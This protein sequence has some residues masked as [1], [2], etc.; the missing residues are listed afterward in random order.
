M[1]ILYAI[2][3]IAVACTAVLVITGL[4]DASSDA[5]PCRFGNQ[6]AP[7]FSAQGPVQDV[8]NAPPAPSGPCHMGP[9]DDRRVVIVPDRRSEDMDR[10]MEFERM[11]AEKER[12]ESEGHRVYILDDGRDDP[13]SHAI[14]EALGEE[15]F[16]TVSTGADDVIH[17]SDIGNDRQD[18][19]FLLD[20]ADV[21]EGVDDGMA[22]VLRSIVD[23][24]HT[25]SSE[26]TLRQMQF[27]WKD[28]FDLDPDDDCIE[29]V[30]VEEDDQQT[31]DGDAEM[32]YQ[33]DGDSDVPCL[34]HVY[35]YSGGAVDGP[36]L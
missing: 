10:I 36:V 11:S 1:R 26:L 6:D 28:E 13:A 31:S 17:S 24:R 5:A 14:R 23:Y 18:E 12:L 15:S 25:V 20:V 22:E 30:D 34:M 29:I 33:Y 9:R 19:Q 3:V 32:E 16:T 4:S 8:T 21:L 2:A 35:R 7:M 27:V